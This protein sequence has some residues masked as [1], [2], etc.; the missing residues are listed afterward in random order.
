M[1][2]WK[3]IFYAWKQKESQIAMLIS[4]KTDF[5]MGQYHLRKRHKNPQ[6]HARKY[7]PTI[8]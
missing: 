7:N 4:D 3:K 5:T 2:G 6:Q 8:H 1:R